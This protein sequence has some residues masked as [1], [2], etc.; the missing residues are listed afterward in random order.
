LQIY[1]ASVSF[2]IIFNSAKVNNILHKFTTA[3][4]KG[5]VQ[6]N[7]PLVFVSNAKFKDE[8][9]AVVDFSLIGI[10]NIDNKNIGVKK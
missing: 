8:M 7:L 10:Y 2:I 4:Q 3:F 5:K 1:F 6:Q 9:Q